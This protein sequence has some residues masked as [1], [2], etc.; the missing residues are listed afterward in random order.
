[1]PFV[2]AGFDAWDVKARAQEI[3]EKLA[4]QD[5]YL[6]STEHKWDKLQHRLAVTTLGTTWYA[7]PV[8]TALGLANVGIDFGRWV[9]DQENRAEAMRTMRSLGTVGVHKMGQLHRALF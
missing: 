9:S 8:N 2:G 5:D 6:N 7:E 3:N 4:D 1:M